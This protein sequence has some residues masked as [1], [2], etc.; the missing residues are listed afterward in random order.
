MLLTALG[1]VAFAYFCGALPFGYWAGKLNGIDIRQHGSKNI[2]ATNVVRVLGKKVGFPVFILDILKGALPTMLAEWWM[3]R[4]GADASTA[5][6]VAVCC[7]AAAVLG[8]TFT[9]WLGFKGGKGVAT[10]AGSLLGLSPTALAIGL[11]AWVITFSISR[12]VALASIVA[13]IVL[14]ISMA[15]QMTLQGTWNYVLLGFAMVMGVLVIVR[16]RANIARM[17]AGTENRFGKKKTR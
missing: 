3:N 4:S 16:H 12:Y 17:L 6:L 15:V 2:G 11:V 5:T 7:A 10:T 14:P 9:F 1:L 8:H 13:A